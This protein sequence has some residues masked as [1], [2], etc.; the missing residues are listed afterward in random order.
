MLEARSSAGQSGVTGVTVS[1]CHE[2]WLVPVGSASL[3]EGMRRVLYVSPMAYG[4]NP[5][6]DAIAHGLQHKLAEGGLELRVVFAD[7]AESDWR[8][9]AEAAVD[10]AVKARYE[11][12]VTY[13][14]DP[15]VPAAA[16]SRAAAAAIPAFTFERPGFPVQGSIVYANFNHGVYLAEHLASALPA[17]A[18]VGVIGGP[19][20]IDDDE[21]VAG[22]VYGVD[23][24][25]L[26]R[27]N[28]PTEA[29]YRNESDIRSGGKEAALRLLSDFPDLDGLVPFN[30]ETMLGALDAFEELG[31]KGIKT[32]SRNGTPLA[33]QAVREG[34]S[35]A[36]WDIDPPA[37]GA[38]MSSLVLSHLNGSAH[39][40]GNLA[41]AP[42]GQIVDQSN[43]DRW[44][45]WLE[46]VPFTAL[47]EGVV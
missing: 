26:R 40:P 35:L 30:D 7:F 46:R 11:A 32:V 41:L 36:T 4:S 14:I 37:I 21:L 33:V 9:K 10:A 22:I 2:P 8:R 28:D 42:I 6:V 34:R 27:M 16:C 23:R 43:A 18:R 12:I 44:K 15:N 38:S 1:W 24:S 20:I 39:E 17:Q 47:L 13:V 45:P 5:G 29:R 31:V 25:G 19:R 3:A